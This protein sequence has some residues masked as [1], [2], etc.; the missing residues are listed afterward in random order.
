MPLYI[1]STPIGNL[2]DVTL[3]ALEVLREAEIIAC[4][5]TRKTGLLLKRHGIAPRGRLRSYHEHNEAARAEELGRELIAGRSIA[6]VTNAGTPLVADP[7]WRLLVKAIELG[8]EVVPVPGANAILAALAA[9]GLAVHRF[10]FLGWPPRKPGKLRHFLEAERENPGTLILFEAP[11]RLA[12]FLAA[13]REVLG[14]RPAAVAREL[15]KLHEE[16][17]RGTLGE[18]AAHYE[19][20]P[21]KGEC[22]VL[23]GGAGA[24]SGGAQG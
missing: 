9:S 24:S 3:R 15:T 13:A 11:Q 18:L 10:T 16:V 4:E 22:T 6:L 12:R 23:I 17:R 8:V 20:S 19:K 21:P 5:D 7:G 2:A 14:E 1:V